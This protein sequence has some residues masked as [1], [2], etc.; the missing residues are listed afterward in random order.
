MRLVQSRYEWVFLC[1]NNVVHV[2]DI[3]D[4]HIVDNTL[5][6]AERYNASIRCHYISQDLKIRLENL[7]YVKMVLLG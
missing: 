4:I 6:E 3:L 7:N 5:T 2:E 1:I